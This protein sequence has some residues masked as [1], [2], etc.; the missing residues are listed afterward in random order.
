MSDIAIWLD[1]TCIV[2][3]GDIVMNILSKKFSAFTLS[4]V[5]ITLG[6][7]GVVSAI[8]MPIL[9][10]NHQKQ[11]TVN[12]LKSAYSTLYQAVQLSEADNGNVGEWDFTKNGEDFYNT[13]LA[14][15]IKSVKT[16]P[17]TEYAEKANIK[18]LNGN[19]CASDN[20]CN[21]VSAT[22]NKGVVLSNG[23]VIIIEGCTVEHCTSLNTAIDINGLKAPNT[24][25]KDIFNFT[26]QQDNHT[27][28]PFGLH[29]VHGATEGGKLFIRDDVV[30]TKFSHSCNKNKLGEYCAGLIMLDGWKIAPDYPW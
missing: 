7:I 21:I 2:K 16:F 15:Y 27:V 17:S 5:L 28:V 12:R 23:T 1:L 30:G 10:Q 14:K 26:I 13:Y 19:I 8:T 22:I 4:E 25:G 6:V 9:V 29:K 18:Y 3:K 24:I 11:T 20:W